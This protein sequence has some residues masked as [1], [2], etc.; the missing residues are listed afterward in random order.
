MHFQRSKIN[1]RSFENEEM[2]NQRLK[3]TFL[4]NFYLWHRCRLYAFNWFSILDGFLL[5][6]AFWFP[7]S[8]S[9][10]RK[11]RKHIL[12][13]PKWRRSTVHTRFSLFFVLPLSTR[14]IHHVYSHVLILLALLI[15]PL[16]YQKNMIK[17]MRVKDKLLL[18][19]GNCKMHKFLTVCRTFIQDLST[20]PLGF[21][22]LI[23]QQILI[24]S[25]PNSSK[26]IKFNHI[27]KKLHLQDNPN[28]PNLKKITL[29]SQDQQA[30]TTHILKNSPPNIFRIM[31]NWSMLPTIHYT[32]LSYRVSGSVIFTLFLPH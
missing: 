15:Y 30:L 19:S 2:S 11:K 8:F 5:R 9:L 16:I 27:S 17:I 1:Q 10:G 12:K 4:D 14:R 7:S 29:N 20:L 31:W 3:S 28:N 24:S 13:A 22:L 26:S 18:I 23:A 32:N 21:K 6:V 25:P